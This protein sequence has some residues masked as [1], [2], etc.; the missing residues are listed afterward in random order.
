MG[1]EEADTVGSDGMKVELQKFE[2]GFYHFYGCWSY[3]KV[4]QSA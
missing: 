3:I 4:M 1:T 2:L